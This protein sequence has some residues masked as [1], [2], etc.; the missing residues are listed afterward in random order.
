MAAGQL[1]VLTR[2]TKERLLVASHRLHAQRRSAVV[3][4][5]GLVADP[6]QAAGADRVEVELVDGEVDATKTAGS[7]PFFTRCTAGGAVNDRC[8]VRLWLTDFDD[9]AAATMKPAADAPFGRVIFLPALGTADEQ[10]HDSMLHHRREKPPIWLTAAPTRRYCYDSVCNRPR[11][12][13]STSAGS[14]TVWATSSRSSS[15]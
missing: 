11:S 2:R 4:I 12:S 8:L 10:S 3:A 9:L 5:A 15:R 6:G 14:A 13:S 7:G 1:P